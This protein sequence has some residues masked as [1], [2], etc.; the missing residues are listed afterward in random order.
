MRDLLPQLSPELHRVALTH[1]A[2][3]AT[4]EQSFERLEFLGDSVLGIA[5]AEAL[6]RRFPD[7]P[8]GRLS[9]MR[10]AIVSRRPCAIVAAEQGLGDA[11]VALAPGDVDIAMV[12]DLAVHERVLAALCESVIG[13]AFLDLGYDIVAPVVVASFE[14]RIG[15]ARDNRIDFKSDLQELA[16]SWGEDIEYRVVSIEGPDHDRQFTMQVRLG[17]AGLE[18]VGAGRTKK[19]AEQVAAGR[20]LDEL[21]ALEGSGSIR[22]RPGGP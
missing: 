6:F 13:A 2:F 11:M 10:A 9:Q 12:R 16:Q 4:P 3:A 14:D 18:A 20:L 8:E 5:I 7:Q 21:M 1:P 17:S 15:H 22:V 19:A